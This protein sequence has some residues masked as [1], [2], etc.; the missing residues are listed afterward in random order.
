M[1]TIHQQARILAKA[2][3]G[4]RPLEADDV[5]G[6]EHE[7]EARFVVYTAERAARSLREAEAAR[8]SD[9]LRRMNWSGA[10]A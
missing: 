1:L 7:V 2:G 6:R 4:V 5:A 8:S 3:I 10:I 9:M